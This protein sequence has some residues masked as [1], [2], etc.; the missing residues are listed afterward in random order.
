MRLQGLARILPILAALALTPQQGVAQVAGTAAPADSVAPKPRPEGLGSRARIT[1]STRNAGFDRWVSAFRGRALA[2]GIS[3]TIFDSAFSDVIYNADVIRRDRSQAEFSLP[4][5]DYLDRAVSPTRIENG[6]EVLDAH[7]ETL[8]RIEDAFGVEKEVV[9]AVWGMESAYGTRRGSENVIEAL[10]TLSYD[11]RR[12]AFFEQQLIAALQILQSGDTAPETMTGSWA[13]AMGHT[14]F[15]PTSYLAY[16]VDFTGDGRR[17]IWADDPTDALA[18]TAAY[19]KRFGW[20]EGQP[21]GVE[22]TL[23]EGFDYA[24]ANDLRVKKSPAEWARL[25]V[26]GPDGQPVADFG[27]ASILLPAGA[28]G[29]AFMAFK[30]FSVISRYNAA[31]AYVIGVGHLADRLRGAE[32]F[33]A[34]WPRGDRALTAAERRELQ[35][36]LTAR[37]FDTRGVDGKIGPRTLQA[38]RDFQRSAGLAPDGYASLALLE[39]LRG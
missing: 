27:P 2:R 28:P 11:A 32:G 36:R 38:I 10:A 7:A 33:V 30:N 5:W 25:G 8:E 6:L 9:V 23:P 39:D 31:D 20:V 37:G 34:E 24:L 14:Q 1:V 21:W 18:S 13:G 4:I 16:A 35:E 17:D 22:V 29:V 15:I 19:L 12:G 3:G 26:T